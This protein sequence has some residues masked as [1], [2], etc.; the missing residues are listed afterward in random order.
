MIVRIMGEGQLEVDAG[1]LDEL[2]R[3][4]DD[5]ASAVDAGD[6]PAFTVALSRLLDRVRATGTPLPDEALQASDLVLPGPDSSLAEVSAL[7][8]DEGLI[9]G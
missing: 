4:D 9:P 5:V 7:L 2:N 3:L 6:E 8:G 1:H